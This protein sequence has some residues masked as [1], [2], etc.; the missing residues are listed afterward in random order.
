MPNTLLIV[1]CYDEAERLDVAAIER[2]A[3][4]HA[5]VGF[6]FVDDGSRDTTPEVLARLVA[7]RPTQFRTLRL[8]KNGGKAEAV[9]QG[10]QAGLRFE[11]KYIGYWD[12]DLAAPLD[13]LP[14]FC[15]VLD[16]RPDVE[17]VIGSRLPL[18]G[19]RIERT[20]FRGW[21]GRAFAR[22]AG[23][24]LGLRL[25]DTQCGA[26]LFRV[27]PATA[28][29]FERPFTSRWIFDVELLAR[30]K[31]SQR[32]AGGT[33][34]RRAVYEQPLGAWQDVGGSRLKARDYFRAVFELVA[35]W[36]TQTRTV[37]LSSPAASASTLLTDSP[38]ADERRAA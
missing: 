17:L 33:T 12:A 18:S 38:P 23:R 3:S 34:L 13:E 28:A 6:L 11:P 10:V 14:A 36:W 26:K 32:A 30:I 21:L 25:V 8:A 1:P 4:A 5:D 9:R 7:R 22:V 31:Q 16:R 24:V 15:D 35:I 19:H 20:R 37:T 29:L 2:F 27:T